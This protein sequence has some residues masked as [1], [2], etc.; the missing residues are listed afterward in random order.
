MLKS[1]C[2]GMC[3]LLGICVI[4]SETVANLPLH[5]FKIWHMPEVL[6]GGAQCNRRSK[7]FTSENIV[8]SSLHT[9]AELVC[10]YAKAI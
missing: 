2:D 4:Y 10:R 8:K 1:A 9:N 6:F 5:I 7:C 3:Y